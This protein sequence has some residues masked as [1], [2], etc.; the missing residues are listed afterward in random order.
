MY[1]TV[2]LMTAAGLMT[3]AGP[4]DP[5]ERRL[6][7][8]TGW[9]PYSVKFGDKWIRY[10]RFEPVGMILGLGA[11][12]VEIGQYAQGGELDKIH[13][14]VMG[15]LMNNLASK[16]F[17]SGVFDF[18]EAMSDPQ[19]YLPRWAARMAQSFVVPNAI[20]QAVWTSD[21]LVREARTIA[22]RIRS[23]IPGKRQEL[24]ALLD[25]AGEPIEQTATTYGLP[26]NVSEEKSDPV[27]EA[28]LRLGIFKGKPGRTLMNV[29]LEDDV[30]NEY[31][32]LMGKTRW[33]HLTP[34]VNSP[35]FRALMLSQP[36]VARQ[37]LE[38]VWDDIGRQVRTAFLY[39]NPEI[40]VKSR[41]ER[42]K[43]RAIGS[44]YL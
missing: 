14:M 25:V 17:L 41:Q 30:Y 42:A 9:Q 35:Q 32:K 23:R 28:M 15:S 33:Q 6:L 18:A 8:R 20:G 5:R 11:D 37:I 39:R 29:K 7:Q 34:L 36:E 24:N 2:G 3:G 26:F 38:K 21:P 44:N 13:A 19:R 43:P 4:D 16:T 22:D 27:A 1:T 40:L 10:N 31:A 12:M